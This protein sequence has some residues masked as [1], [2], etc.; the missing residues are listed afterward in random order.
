[1][2][3]NDRRVLRNSLLTMGFP[4]DSLDTVSVSFDKLDKIGADGV[5][6]ELREKACP[7]KRS[8]ACPGFSQG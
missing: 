7:R 5:A 3:V 6:A 4:E 2:R 8:T 1:M